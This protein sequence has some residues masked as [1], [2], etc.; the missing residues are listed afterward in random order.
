MEV[1]NMKDMN[2]NGLDYIKA[3]KKL[4]DSTVSKVVSGKK[5]HNYFN[6]KQSI[7]VAG[8]LSVIFS[9]AIF[10]SSSLKENP[11]NNIANKITVDS[12]ATP[13]K[14]IPN[15]IATNDPVSGK[16]T[17]DSSAAPNKSEQTP[18]II[19]NK[20]ASSSTTTNSSVISKT[21]VQNHNIPAGNNSGS[22]SN[23]SKDIANN[24]G[25]YISPINLNPSNG[26]S[27][28][29]IALVVY[30]G[31]VYTQSATEIASNNIENFLGEKIG[32]TTNSINEW[33]VKD[34][35]SEELASNI[36]EQDIYTV[37]GYD[38]NF[39]IMSYIKIQDQEYIQFFDCLNGITIKNGNDVFGKLN[40]VNNVESAEF[41][42]FDDW[43]NGVNNYATFQD[44][45][46]LNE[47]LIE[48][49]SATPYNCENVENDIDNSR[50]NND[51]RQFALKLKDGSELKFNAFKSGY[52]SYGYSNIY[53]KV[54][55]SVIEKL[56]K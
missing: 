33:N 4:I 55:A 8:S 18:S 44:L 35:S 47:A 40:L 10:Y 22:N 37:K 17:E 12:N 38:T 23:P 45:D 52:V 27:A 39:R 43:N 48:L 16:A 29:M 54:N 13:N 19:T 28:K 56:W 25:I 53:F 6:T 49:N 2:F 46:I 1:L 34:K 9:S 21:P 26:T 41:I 20:N 24:T 14:I 15:N 31:K 7:A 30:N 51:F 36:G 50:N 5:R 3:D 11:N 42:S 32:R